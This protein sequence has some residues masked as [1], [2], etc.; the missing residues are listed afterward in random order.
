MV[1]N[2]H[3][4]AMIDAELCIGCGICASERCQVGAIEESGDTFRVIPDRCIGCGLCISACPTEAIQLVRKEQAALTP[5]PFTE[6]DWFKERGQARGV[7]FTA[8]K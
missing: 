5:P 7:D 8:H 4:Y 6:D 3:Y 1:V 2:A